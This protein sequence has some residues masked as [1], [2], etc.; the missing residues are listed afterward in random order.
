MEIYKQELLHS[1]AFRFDTWVELVGFEM[2]TSDSSFKLNF[3]LTNSQGVLGP[4]I[5]KGA[6]FV[7]RGNILQPSA[8]VKLPGFKRLEPN[9][10]YSINVMVHIHEYEMLLVTSAGSDGVTTIETESGVRVEFA[11]G[12]ESSKKTSTKGGLISGLVFHRIDHA[13]EAFLRRESGTA[14]RVSVSTFS[15]RLSS[16]TDEMSDVP[17]PLPSSKPKSLAQYP[18]PP[19][20]GVIT[21]PIRTEDVLKLTPIVIRA[22]NSS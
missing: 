3:T 5:S 1:I 22:N 8:V 7:P 10:W 2:L 11:N 12:L 15:N 13:E 19:V 17:C 18:L 21:P 9:Q 16:E 4:V 6:G 20:A 14:Q